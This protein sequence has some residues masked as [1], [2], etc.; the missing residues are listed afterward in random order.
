MRPWIGVG[1]DK[2]NPAREG[3]NRHKRVAK[4]MAA[5]GKTVQ[6]FL[7]KGGAAATLRNSIRLGIAALK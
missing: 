4:L 3:S 7:D 1:S 2:A 5:Y 6:D